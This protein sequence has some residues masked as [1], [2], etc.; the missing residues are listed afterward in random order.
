MKEHSVIP[1][2]YSLSV[3]KQAITSPVRH[4]G[5]SEASKTAPDSQLTAADCLLTVTD[6]HCEQ[7]EAIFTAAGRHLSEA[8]RQL[9]AAGRPLTTADRPLAL[10]DC[11]LAATDWQLTATDRLLTPADWSFTPA[12]WASPSAENHSTSTKTNTM[13]SDKPQA[14]PL[15]V[16][17]HEAIKCVAVYSSIFF[18]S[19][20]LKCICILYFSFTNVTNQYLIKTKTYQP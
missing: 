14:Y 15:C 17:R 1:P 16:A 2:V 19:S 3:Q 12:D 9:K 18:V 6:W 4:C 7:S 10:P 8:D 13:Y 20:A 11:P 5:Q